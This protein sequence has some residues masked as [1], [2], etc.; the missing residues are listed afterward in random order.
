MGKIIHEAS[1]AAI[2][3]VELQ[4]KQHLAHRRIERISEIRSRFF[5]ETVIL[6]SR[7]AILQR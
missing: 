5:T 2:S 3:T 7:L 4:A 1:V 6:W